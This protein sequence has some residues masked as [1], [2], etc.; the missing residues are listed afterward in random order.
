MRLYLV[1]HPKP[2]VAQGM[3]YGASD[4]LCC[5]DALQNAA[6]QL[7]K[8]LPKS[9]H[10]ISSPLSR[11][12]RLAQYLCRLEPVFTYKTDE[13]IRE[14]DFGAW[15]M[16]SWD[17]IGAKE[18]QAW[19]D[20]FSHYR[21]GGSGESAA[22]FVQRVAQRL[23]ASVQTAEDQIWITHAGVIRAVE[24]LLSQPREMLTEIASSQTAPSGL[25][26]ADWPKGEVAF[27]RLHRTLRVL[28]W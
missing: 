1:R 8:E 21:C 10:I 5:E 24:W 12:E 18:L 2:E 27:G 14:M 16:R 19:T 20:N 23:H 7:L 9:L 15:E 4:V 13:K 28:H 26:A 11:C 3:C 22:M 6:T 25:L 17:V